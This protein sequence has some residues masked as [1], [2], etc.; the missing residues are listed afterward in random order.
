MFLF[1]DCIFLHLFFFRI[2]FS[3]CFCIFA[4]FLHYLIFLISAAKLNLNNIIVVL[5]VVVVVAVVVVVVV[6]VVVACC[7]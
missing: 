5:V 3:L 4:C 7:W 1:G 2:W 6:V